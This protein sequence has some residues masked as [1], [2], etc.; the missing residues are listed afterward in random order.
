MVQK[1]ICPSPGEPKTTHTALLALEDGTT[2]DSGDAVVR[3][4]S[5]GGALL[6]GIKTERQTLPLQNFTLLI[7]LNDVPSLEGIVGEC[8]IVRLA[9]SS[10]DGE[11]E[12]GV[13]FVNATHRDRRRIQ[14][15]VDSRVGSRRKGTGEAGSDD[16]SDEA[17][18]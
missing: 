10:E 13:R 12:L 11:P 1:G 14:E 18:E 16:E 3:N 9:G 17:E 5:V 6:T 7:R 4:L 15:Y 8:E 2:F